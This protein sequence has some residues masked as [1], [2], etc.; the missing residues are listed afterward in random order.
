MDHIVSQS[1]SVGLR[2]YLEEVEAISLVATV[3][4]DAT[5]AARTGAKGPVSLCLIN[6]TLPGEVD[7]ELGQNYL[8]SPQIKG[9]LKSLPGVLMVE[10]L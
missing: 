6:Q 1:G 10:D 2:V 5:K 3:L 9:A 8:V 4:E 7:M